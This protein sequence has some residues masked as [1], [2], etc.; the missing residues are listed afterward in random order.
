MLNI[1]N[2]AVVAFSLA[3]LVLYL[4]FKNPYS[5]SICRGKFLYLYRH[6]AD[7]KDTVGYSYS[8]PDGIVK[9]T[10][11]FIGEFGKN[12]EEAQQKIDRIY[13]ER[14]PHLPR[15]IITRRCSGITDYY[16]I[17]IVIF[18]ILFITSIIDILTGV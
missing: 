15:P 16:W 4:L 3:F 11:E 13:K 17:P 14:R 5:S 6:E 12:K 10:K 8:E 7:Y 18:V 9:A 1:Y 2:G